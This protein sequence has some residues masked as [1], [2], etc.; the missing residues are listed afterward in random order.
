MATKT[1]TRTR[2]W[3]NRIPLRKQVAVL[4]AGTLITTASLTTYSALALPKT[5]ASGYDQVFYIN[6]VNMITPTAGKTQDVNPGD[7]VC[8]NAAGNCSLRAALEEVNANGKL[9][10]KKV[11][12]TV[13]I[14]GTIDPNGTKH[15]IV[16]TTS[17]GSTCT[18]QTVTL[19]DGTT[20]PNYTCTL[21][22]V[23]ATNRMDTLNPWRQLT[24]KAYSPAMPLVASGTNWNTNLLNG[25]WTN[26]NTTAP[27]AYQTS[28]QG[29][30]FT[31]TQ[32][33]TIDLQKQ[34]TYNSGTTGTAAGAVFFLN[35]NNITLKGLYNT[36]SA[37][38]AIVVG[39]N[40]QNV[41]VTDGQVN[42][43]NNYP[44]RFMIIRGGSRNTTLSYFTIAG[45]NS[46]GVL[47]NWISLA[48]TSNTV[49]VGAVTIDHVRFLANNTGSCNTTT[50]LGCNSSGSE[51]ANGVAGHNYITDYTFTNN[52][53]SNLN[54][55]PAPY[56]YSMIIDARLSTFKNITIT[57]NIIDNPKMYSWGIVE[58]GSGGE[59]AVLGNVTINN[60][61]VFGLTDAYANTVMGSFVKMPQNKVIAGKG[62]ISN[63]YVQFTG[64]SGGTPA[65]WWDSYNYSVSKM[66]GAGDTTTNSTSSALT[67][68]NLVIKNNYFDWGQ[69]TN[70]S[71]VLLYQTGLVDASTNR[72]SPNTQTQTNTTVEEGNQIYAGM[73]ANYYSNANAKLNT[74]YPTSRTS[75]NVQANPVQAN[76]CV[77]P[78]Q[79]APP[80]DAANTSD[81]TYARYP[82][83]TA[84]NPIQVDVFWTAANDA[85]VYLGRFPVTNKAGSNIVMGASNNSNGSTQ[86]TSATKPNYVLGLINVPL[87]FAGDDRLTLAGGPNSTPVGA[88][89]MVALNADGSAWGST[90]YGDTRDSSQSPHVPNIG[91]GAPTGWAD[92]AGN[93]NGLGAQLVPSGTG[94]A[95]V[96]FGYPSTNAA[97]GPQAPKAGPVTTPGPV[98]KT[99]NVS[100][101]LRVQTLDF[102][103]NKYM[104]TVSNM[105]RVAA[106]SGSCAP[107][108]TLQQGNGKPTGTGNTVDPT[109]SRIMHFTLTSSIALDTSTWSTN[110]IGTTATA[111]QPV[112]NAAASTATTAVYQ[113][114]PFILTSSLVGAT[115][116]YPTGANSPLTCSVNPDTNTTQALCTAAKGTWATT[117]ITAPLVPS[118]VTTPDCQGA[119]GC[120]DLGTAVTVKAIDATNTVFDVA[121]SVNDSATV[122]LAVPAGA[123]TA[124][125]SKGGLPNPNPATTTDTSVYG[126]IQTVAPAVPAQVGPPAVAAKPIVLNP[127]SNGIPVA[128]VTFENPLVVNPTAVLAVAND[129]HTKSY[130]IKLLPGAPTP[131]QPVVF[132]LTLPTTYNAIGGAKTC[133]P[134]QGS[135][136]PKAGAS[137]QFDNSGWAA[138]DVPCAFFVANSTTT[139]ITS[140]V[141][142][143]GSLTAT[144][145]MPVPTSST[146]VAKTGPIQVIVTDGTITANTRV[147]VTQVVTSGDANYLGLVVPNGIVSIFS[148][149][150]T[151]SLDI[152]AYVQPGRYENGIWE[153]GAYVNGSWVDLDSSLLLPN[154]A[155]TDG[156]DTNGNPGGLCTSGNL[157]NCATADPAVIKTIVK[158]WELVCDTTPGTL[159]GLS[160]DG[161]LGST[162]IPYTSLS[163]LCGNQE[164]ADGTVKYGISGGREWVSIPVCYV[165]TATNEPPDTANSNGGSWPALLSGVTYFTSDTSLRNRQGGVAND[166]T[167]GWAGT[168]Y[169]DGTSDAAGNIAQH[170]A[171][172]LISCGITYPNVVADDGGDN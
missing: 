123:V 129:P 94:A 58:F 5:T 100:G 43:P 80:S 96:N 168:V 109:M 30:Y 125:G 67:S 97:D 149:N 158:N 98:D 135:I 60:N 56:P 114:G 66:N 156:V 26:N 113:V 131:T 32:P 44:D 62:S 128:S 19:V 154:I 169:T 119:A 20:T 48:G 162:R 34:L 23:S 106:I 141:A 10:G 92:S 117:P 126:P 61:S 65:I 151:P 134:T 143:S 91:T 49:P 144:A 87:P 57:N 51:A 86:S 110:T 115:D 79:I 147:P 22:T 2:R 121:V 124:A 82:Q 41:T 28:D 54:N 99:G 59:S 16:G 39:P 75:A 31:V 81:T 150:N 108:L 164:A 160:A 14:N 132:G 68:S 127:A 139:T 102:T 148:T 55:S 153:P 95:T 11:L 172:Q 74:W 47:N 101:Y 15:P 157:Q 77:V 85:E 170:K 52:Y 145:T 105:S 6:D 9:A 3:F 107:Q 63:N 35:S 111:M 103:A 13:D 89:K 12:I 171:K 21:P 76:A 122:T 116:T 165:Y 72:Y 137:G 71:T 163:N 37:N 45:F 78:L 33:V 7:G 90:Y 104:P 40:S 50:A 73:L 130:A 88:G 140:P 18:S 27:A 84:T 142:G 38:T 146:A 161:T 4:V 1:E 70:G 138:T 93:A 17:T 112:Y 133:T 152:T 24:T 53:M 120:L 159:Q 155:V 83:G 69:K 25:N 8:A 36:Y 64:T 136:T 46:D 118:L 167:L 29:S 42:T 166:N